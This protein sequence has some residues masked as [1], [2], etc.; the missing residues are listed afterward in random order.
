MNTKRFSLMSVLAG[1]LAAT[2]VLAASFT[3]DLIV[4]ANVP[5][6]CSVS[7]GPVAF[8]PYNA[9]AI[10]TT[11]S[12]TANCTLGITYSVGLGPGNSATA[13]SRQMTNAGDATKK[14]NYE[15]YKDSLR[16]QR[17]GGTGYAVSGATPMTGLTSTA[18]DQTYTIYAQLPGSQELVAG[19]FDDT[20][21]A[22]VDY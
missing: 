6:G 7:T 19:G 17:W 12:V 18:T 14:L 8:G 11:G 5:G 2:P 9:G 3:A 1:V 16:S 15:L 4:S 21:V 22:S 10:N 13:T 20:V